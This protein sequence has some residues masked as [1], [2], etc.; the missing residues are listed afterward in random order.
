MV[1][2]AKA[3]GNFA[4]NLQKKEGNGETD[5][6]WRA[7]GAVVNDGC[8]TG[9]ADSAVEERCHVQGEGVRGRRRS[10]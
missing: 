8:E 4:G 3:E 1:A 2:R 6:I 5:V 7:A 9:G 10:R